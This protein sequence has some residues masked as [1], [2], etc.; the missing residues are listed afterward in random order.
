MSPTPT[1]KLHWLGYIPQSAQFMPLATL[2]LFNTSFDLKRE[3]QLSYKWL[4]KT[5][6]MKN[7]VENTI[8]SINIILF[9]MLCNTLN[10]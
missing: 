5:D 9:I 4:Q 2:L 7:D 3:W 8:F 10:L 6:G 1:L